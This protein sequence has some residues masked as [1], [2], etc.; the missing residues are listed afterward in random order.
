MPKKTP[1]KLK[2]PPA[3][4]AFN[5]LPVRNWCAT[6]RGVFHRLH[7]LDPAT[8]RPRRPVSFSQRGHTRFDPV[9]GVGT[10]CLGESLS[11]VLLEVFD[12]R[13]GSVGDITRSLTKTELEEWWVTLV[14]V[15]AMTAFEAHKTNLSKLGTDL[16][17]VSGDHAVAREW[18]L[19]LMRHP[20][21]VEGIQYP[22]RHDDSRV[23]LAL[24]QVPRLLPEQ[25]DDSVLPPAAAHA[26]LASRG[27]GRLVYGPAVLLRDHPELDASLRE[28]EIALIP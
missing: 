6:V 16:Q 3:Q 24:F 9:K 12:D 22:S 15:P 14:A 18:A 17:L 28:L 11:G 2:P 25:Y 26:L 5:R 23:N 20:A 13:W 4:R 8:G 19:R 21:A 10:L 7:S 1:G 27:Q